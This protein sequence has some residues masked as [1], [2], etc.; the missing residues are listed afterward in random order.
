MF[1]VLFASPW[2]ATE[3]TAWILFEDIVLVLMIRQNLRETLGIAERQA[4]LEGV[5]ET[6]ERT[7][8]ERTSELRREIAER[9]RVEET[10]R[11]LNSAVEQS[12][13]SILITDAEID[14]PGPRIIFVNPAFTKLTGYSAA[15]ALGKITPHFTGTQHR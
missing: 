11:L 6:I 9:E 10:L 5:N 1:G 15:E 7:V 2:R 14:L 3:H 8:A 13:E 12:K 4:R